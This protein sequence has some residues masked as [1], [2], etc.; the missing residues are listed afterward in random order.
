[1]GYWKNPIPLKNTSKT[2]HT[3]THTNTHTQYTLSLHWLALG[4]SP[5][6]SE[7]ANGACIGFSSTTFILTYFPA[8]IYINT[9]QSPRKGWQETN[10]SPKAEVKSVCVHACLVCVCLLLRDALIWSS[11]LLRLAVDQRS[12]CFM[13]LLNVDDSPGRHLD[14]RRADTNHSGHF[15]LAAVPRGFFVSAS[16]R[17]DK[18]WMCSQCSSSSRDSLQSVLVQHRGQLL[19]HCSP[20]CRYT[21]HCKYCT[22]RYYCDTWYCHYYCHRQHCTQRYYCYSWTL[23]LPPTTPHTE[24]LLWYMILL[25]LQLP[26]TLYTEV[27]LWYMILLLLQLPPALFTK[28]L[29][30]HM[31]LLLLPPQPLKLLV[32]L[33]TEPALQLFTTGTRLTASTVHRGTMWYMILLLLLPPLIPIVLLPLPVLCTVGTVRN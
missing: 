4:K 17:L 13:G 24:V 23:L 21:T 14:S 6:N 26:L 12:P 19:L 5:F 10:Y 8:I 18:E 15:K 33:L 29:L 9:P 31:K 30:W 27:Q 25:L 11:M 16:W 20:A 2:T 28:V 32:L 3:H 1:M 7:A 22:Q